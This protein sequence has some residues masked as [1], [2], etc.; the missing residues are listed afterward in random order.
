MKSP[1]DRSSHNSSEN[2]SVVEFLWDQCRNNTTPP[3][4][5][6]GSAIL[7]IPPTSI[8]RVVFADM[9]YH[10]SDG[11]K[12]RQV[13]AHTFQLMIK[14]SK[15]REQINIYQTLHIA[16]T[17]NSWNWIDP[18]PSNF[19]FHPENFPN[20]NIK[21]LIFLADLGS[22][23]HGR[24]RLACSTRGALCVLKFFCKGGAEIKELDFWKIIYPKSKACIKTF[25][26]QP[27]LLMP[28]FPPCP[29]QQRQD[30]EV[31]EAVKQSIDALLNKGVH[32]GDIKWSNFGF[33]RNKKNKLF[34]L[35]FDFGKSV[36]FSPLDSSA[37]TTYKLLAKQ[38]IE[39]MF[40]QNK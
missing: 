38:E 39:E 2:K 13:I 12:L 16:A 9:I 11:T 3:S 35:P 27:A 29:P 25:M 40:R 37:K 1:I 6:D 20:K 7:S 22:G 24:V 28:L 4:E 30:D 36:I 10:I 15:Y 23:L 26:G 14:F 17:N 21:Q 34:A 8:K 5:E 33:V 31:K 19:E 18:L 32:H